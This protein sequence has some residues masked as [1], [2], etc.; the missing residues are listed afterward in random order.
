MALSHSEAEW[1]ARLPS[2]LA[3]VLM[4]VLM[5]DLTTRWLGRRVGGIAGLIQATFVYILVQGR[6]AEADMP[7]AAAVCL[8]MYAFARVRGGPT[9]APSAGRPPATGALPR[10]AASA[11]LAAVL[12]GD[13]LSFLLK[14]VGPVFI[15]AAVR[16][17]SRGVR[18]GDRDFRPARRFLL[19]PGGLLLL[20]ANG[21]R[22]AAGGLAYRA[23]DD[24]RLAPGDRRPVRRGDGREARLALLPGHRPGLLMPWL[25][26]ALGGVYRAAGGGP[27]AGRRGN[28]CCAGSFP[29]C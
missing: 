18:G 3:A 24:E 21:G 28:S 13:G 23:G 9:S 6:L 17:V 12:P 14:G 26:F 5:A 15:L 25:P 19:N 1:V 20:A 2:G 16:G 8:A 10:A 27:S 22:L 11:A 29:G 7:M 4:A